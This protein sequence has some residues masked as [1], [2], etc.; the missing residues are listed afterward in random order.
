MPK[1]SLN[2]SKKTKHTPAGEIPVDWGWARLSEVVANNK[3]IVYGIVQ[4]GPHIA[5]GVPY[6][7]STDVGSNIEI[8]SLLRT[9]PEIAGKYKRSVVKPG[10]IVFSLRGNIGEVSSVPPDLPE[11]N[12][13]QG[14]ARISVSRENSSAY[15]KQALI[16]PSVSKRILVLAKGSTFK[17]ITL[18][19]LRSLELPL[20]PL[21]EQRRIADILTTWDRAIETLESLIAAKERR[22]QALMQQLLTHTDNFAKAGHLR[23]R[24]GEVI[25]RVTRKNPNGDLNVLTISAQQGLVSQSSYFNRNV[26]GEDLSKYYQLKRGEFAY[27]RSSSKGFPFGAIKR[28][29]AYPTGVVSTLYL[30]FRITDETRTCSDF[31]CHYFDSGMLNQGLR[32]VAQ[33]GARAHGLLNVTSTDFMDLDVC[34]PDFATQK[35]IAAVLDTADRELSL[36]RQHLATLRTQKRGL[37]KLLLTGAVR[38]KS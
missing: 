6:I 14:T 30:C 20:P 35:R 31:L 23:H 7:R 38:V 34:L 2:A 3:P 1:L 27:N 25:E 12:L 11:A 15:V 16:A 32:C 8:P 36:H 18:E 24:L 17:E 9:S 5:N 13:T 19:D 37:M 29:N 22:K 10:D 4:A 26:A 28:L 33:E 21:P